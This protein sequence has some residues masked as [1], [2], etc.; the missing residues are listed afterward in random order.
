MG[1]WKVVSSTKQ[2]RDGAEIQFIELL[3]LCTEILA[4]Q[5]TDENTW[6]PLEFISTVTVVDDLNANVVFAPGQAGLD[7]K[8]EH[9]QVGQRSGGAL[10]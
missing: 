7:V 5:N 6:L 1:G 3:K 8:V 10:R 4:V 2:V 9:R